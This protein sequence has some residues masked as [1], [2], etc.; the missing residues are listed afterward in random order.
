MTSTFS[1]DYDQ[2]HIIYQT[3]ELL[4]WSFMK[5]VYVKVLIFINQGNVIGTYLYEGRGA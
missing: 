5:Y 4:H 3:E 1:T 2:E